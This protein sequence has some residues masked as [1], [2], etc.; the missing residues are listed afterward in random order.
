MPLLKLK[1]NRRNIGDCWQRFG[2][3]F[4]VCLWVLLPCTPLKAKAPGSVNFLLITID[5]IR[6]DHIGCYGYQ[7]IKTPH[8]DQL[9]QRGILFENAFTPVPITLPSHASI[10]TG[11]YP[12]FHGI[13]NNGTYALSDAD[14]TLAELL[15]SKGYVTAAFVSA[16]VLDKRFGLDQGFDVYNDDLSNSPEERF[17]YTERRA[18]ATTKA[19]IQW[20]KETNPSKF[21]LW[22]HYFDPH[23]HYSPPEPFSVEYKD[24]LYDGEIAYTDHWLGRLIENMDQL[25]LMKNTHIILTGDH[26]EGLGDHQE[27]THGIFIYDTTLKVPLI[28]SCQ[29]LF[30]KS[31]RIKNL[32]RLIDIAPTIMAL[33]GCKPTDVMQGASLLPLMQGQKTRLERVLYC[34]SYYPQFSHN[35]SPL[36]GMRTEKWKYIDAPIQELYRVD[37]DPGE[38]K[39]LADQQKDEAERLSS[40]F[41]NLKTQITASSVKLD[42]QKLSLDEGTKEKLQSLGYVFTPAPEEEK[43][44][45]PD[46]KQMIGMLTFFDQGLEYFGKK[47]YQMAKDEFLKVVRKYPQDV[48]AHTI[49][50]HT[51]EALGEYEKSIAAFE[52]A[53]ELGCKDLRIYIKLGHIYMEQK[54]HPKGVRM[55]Q[56]ALRINPGC[57]EAYT[58]LGLYHLQK[59]ELDQAQ[60][61]FQNSLKIDPLDIQIHDQ[62]AV[63]YQR[64]KRYEEAIITSQKVLDMDPNHVPALLSLGSTF[65]FQHQYQK[66]LDIL[67]KALKIKPR[68]SRIHYFAGLATFQQ[69]EWDQSIAYFK[70][71]IELNPKW[72]KPHF[73]LGYI[74]QQ[75]KDFDSAIQEYQN[76][77]QLNPDLTQAQR[78]IDQIRFH[79]QRQNRMDRNQ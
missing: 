53:L 52:R 20:F 4:L 22:V 31:K 43:G 76:A 40:M 44:T 79:L 59:G 77:L 17:L 10:L 12:T 5:T 35:W 73:N 68:S 60:D 54:R 1:S 39:N 56:E 16:Y 69:R 38:K 70:K 29:M 25:G 47:E 3:S 46:P 23:L 11:M 30:P 37:Q 33:A 66:A 48:D 21:F 18:E 34:E 14:V 78:M 8:M 2:V 27:K 26:G 57:K 19:V 28:W 15:K 45:Y 9:A 74:Y 36:L 24:N 49:L 62:L 41:T 65:L 6:S 55:F 13:R 75:L 50:G 51:Y 67:K 42:A 61:Y 64:Q 71:A 32:V 7:K 72:A 63:V 58:H